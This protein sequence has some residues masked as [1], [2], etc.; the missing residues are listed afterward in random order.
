MKMILLKKI[1]CFN[2][3]SRK[4]VEKQYSDMTKRGKKD[5]FKYTSKLL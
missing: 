4:R 5:V 2:K 3:I 1:R